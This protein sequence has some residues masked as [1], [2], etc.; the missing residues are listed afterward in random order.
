MRCA[1]KLLFPFMLKMP[2]SMGK[3]NCIFE[4]RTF[5]IMR[6]VF[7]IFLYSNSLYGLAAVMLAM[8]H[9]LLCGLPLNHPLF[10]VVLFCGTTAFYLF[11]Y[12]YD[13]HP[14]KGN[15][16]ARWISRNRTSLLLFRN[17][18]SA[19]SCIGLIAYLF[20]LPTIP[21]ATMIMY[22]LLISLSPLLGILYY[23]ISFP[24]FFKVRLRQ[25]GW[26][27][28]FT[29][30]AV[31]A[32]CVSLVPWLLVHWELYPFTGGKS[33]F[34]FLWLHNW[35][36]ISV[37]C[38]LF[39]IKDYAADHNQTLKTFVVRVGLRKLI[40]RIV[41][42]LIFAGTM[43]LFMFMRLHHF[44]TESMVLNLVPMLALFWVTQS[45]Q[46][47]RSIEYFLVVIDGLM[48]VKAVFGLLSVWMS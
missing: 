23:G 41:L 6:R 37:L 36:Y 13:Q 35:M 1:L 31:W 12:Q 17:T 3:I 9:N 8:E 30:G 42:P 48:V 10:Y 26:F 27:K 22:V 33:G 7:S 18:L 15:L 40:F 20:M 44:S 4:T 47:R 11:S 24:G 43:A 46:Q 34:M 32:G 16:R 29:I 45:L 39:D 21:I 25:F 19:I 14:H 28:P 38:I 2:L 5:K